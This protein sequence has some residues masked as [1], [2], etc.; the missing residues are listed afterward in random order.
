M[1]DEKWQT[2]VADPAHQGIRTLSDMA[3]LVSPSAVLTMFSI[4]QSNQSERK[5]C[6]AY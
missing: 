3:K 1:F 6:P 4:P 2:Y 5:S